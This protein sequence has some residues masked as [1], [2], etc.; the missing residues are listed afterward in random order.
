[1][2]SCIYDYQQWCWLITD[3]ELEIFASTWRFETKTI[4]ES[5]LWNLNQKEKHFSPATESERINYLVTKLFK[6]IFFSL[7]CIFVLYESVY[8]I[9]IHEIVGF[10]KKSWNSV[11]DKENDYLPFAHARLSLQNLKEAQWSPSITGREAG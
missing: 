6:N 5:N 4:L 8:Y 10:K 9:S 11:K 7:C 2:V 3:L 1:M